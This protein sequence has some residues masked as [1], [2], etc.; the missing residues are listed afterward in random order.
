[1]SETRESS[2]SSPARAPLFGQTADQLRALAIESGLKPFA[3]R[4]IA[5]WLYHRHAESLAAMTNLPATARARLAE[6]WII[7]RSAPVRMQESSDGTRKYLYAAAHPGRFVETAWIPDRDRATLCV[8]TQVGCKMG[9]A[10][11]MTAQQGF[12]G[13]L[14]AGE[15][16]NQYASLPERDA[17]TNIVYMGMGEPLDNLESVLASIEI[18]TS[19]WGYAMSPRRITVS[20]VGLIPAM[21][22]FLAR[23]RCHLAVSLHSPFDDERRQWMPIQNVYPISRVLEELRRHPLERQRRI[24]FEYICFDGINDT[25]RHVKEMARAMNGLRARVNLMRFHPVPG[26]PLMGSSEERLHAFQQ[27]LQQ[28]GIVATIRRS[29]GLDIAAA[30]GLLSTREQ[31]RAFPPA[32][33]WRA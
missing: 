15:I 7:G 30:C 20:T 4:Q 21:K 33:G 10:F 22:E 31:I 2:A 28:K 5:E 23:C 12:Q 24:S 25:P 6:R 26:I 17:V 11:C 18:L 19:D 14:S 29:R 9:C 13:Q 1:M 27:G 3:A 32:A 16:L 8:S